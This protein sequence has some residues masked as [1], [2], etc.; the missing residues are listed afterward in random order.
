MTNGDASSYELVQP[1]ARRREWQLR[2]G[3][4]V[5]A[6]LRIPAFR[7]GGLA[8]I[9]DERLE[10]EQRG[11]LRPDYVVRDERTG[12]EVTRLRRDG[13]RLLL[14]LDGRAAEWKRL[15]RKEGFGFV[16]ADAQPLVIA[17]VRSG[18]VRSSGH[19]SV[20]PG[21]AEREAIV[22]AL[23]AAYLLIRRN[24]DEPAAASAA[25]LSGSAATS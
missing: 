7:S 6:V 9:G 2:L 22:A 11:R 25:A 4:E 8:E 10:I 19:V 17:K 23:L 5:R 18:L 20:G 21:L 13:R 24:E 1:T 12:Q 3:D 16:A 14:D 15:G